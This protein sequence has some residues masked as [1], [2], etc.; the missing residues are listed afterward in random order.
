MHTSQS[1]SHTPPCIG[2]FNRNHDVKVSK[3][4]SGFEDNSTSRQEIFPVSAPCLFSPNP[5]SSSSSDSIMML[6]Y[7]RWQQQR[8]ARRGQSW[9]SAA[10]VSDCPSHGVPRKSE[11]GYKS[12]GIFVSQLPLLLKLPACSSLMALNVAEL[13]QK[14]LPTRQTGQNQEFPWLCHHWWHHWVIRKT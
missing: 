11:A 10:P 2:Y 3:N 7:P 1:T 14:V 13:S 5:S 6:L 9:R 8:R 4:L 12:G